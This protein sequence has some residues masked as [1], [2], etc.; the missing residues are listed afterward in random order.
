M[1]INIFDVVNSYRDIS[2]DLLA[3]ALTPD[4]QLSPDFQTFVRAN[5]G[6]CHFSDMYVFGDS[7]CDIGNA[8]DTTQKALGEGRP[9]SPPYFQGRF[10]NGPVWIEFLAT[11]LGLT[12]R[13][14]TNFAIGGANTGSDNTLIPNNPLRL[15]GLQQQINS[16]IGDLKAVN[17][18]ADCEA[19]YIIWAGAN[20]Y[21]GGG[22]TQPAI[23]IKNLSDAVASLAAVGAKHIMVLNLPDLGELPATRKNSQQSALLNALTREHNVGLAKSLSSLS[24]GSDVNIILFDVHS[25]FNQVLTNPTKFGFTNVTDSQLDQLEHLQNYTDKFLFWDVIHPTTTS[26]MIFAK[27]AFSL[28]TP[29]VEARLS[30]YQYNLSN[31]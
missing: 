20:D 14:N 10:S 15:S 30:N 26:H 19:V 9:P 25:L 5:T 22:L 4:E 7:L 18:L 24:L 31:L 6:R 29:A 11:L 3:A 27:F 21:L 17:R 13:R 1:I 2:P 8:F 16:F 12:S 23:P 28:L